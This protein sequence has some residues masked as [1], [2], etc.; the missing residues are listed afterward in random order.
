MRHGIVDLKDLTA[1][2]LEPLLLKQTAEWREKLDWDFSKSANLLR[3]LAALF[4]KGQITSYAYAGLE[5]H[6][7]LI[8]DV[9]PESIL[10]G[11]LLEALTEIPAVTRIEGQLM[12]QESPPPNV[13]LYERQ[14]FV[15]GGD[16]AISRVLPPALKPWDNQSREAAAKVI[17]KAYAGHPDSQMNEHYQ[18]ESGAAAYVQNIETFPGSVTFH[19]PASFLAR[20]NAGEAVGTIL[21][22]FIAEEVAHIAEICVTPEARG[23]GLGYQ[24]LQQAIAALEA[25]GAKRISLAVTTA[26][27]EAIKLYTRRGFREQRRFYA[28]V[29]EASSRS[30]SVRRNDSA[31][32]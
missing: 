26:N 18:T 2:D 9:Y 20:D 14:L 1:S 4:N 15:F 27:K 25:A 5:G 8:A 21:S 22:A 3:K 7:G 19:A 31:S 30:S 32:G 11:A 29:W 17:A 10:F 28:F 6:K 12:L 13:T 16:A 23:A 24:L